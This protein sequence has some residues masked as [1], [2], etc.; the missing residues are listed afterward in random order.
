M[1]E[2]K[3]EKEDENKKQDNVKQDVKKPQEVKM[4]GRMKMK[5][6]KVLSNRRETLEDLK[7]H[8]YPSR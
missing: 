4:L 5:T 7:N 6:P 8:Q 2:L 3:K 1:R